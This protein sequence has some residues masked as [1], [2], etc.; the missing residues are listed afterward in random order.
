MRPR[1][2]SIRGAYEA[3]NVQQT[4]LKLSGVVHR[5]S[6]ETPRSPESAG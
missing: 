6:Y 4:V 3:C 5:N 1:L 2:K